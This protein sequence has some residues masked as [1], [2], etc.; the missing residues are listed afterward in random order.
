MYGR[1]RLLSSSPPGGLFSEPCS[2]SSKRYVV[3]EVVELSATGFRRLGLRRLGSAFRARAAAGRVAIAPA[4]ARA[5]HLHDVRDDLGG[6]LVL[7]VLVLPLARLQASFDVDLRALLEVLAR[8]LRELAEEGDAVPFRLLLHLAR[9]VLPLVGGR[10]GNVRDRA[11]VRHVARLRI[12]S[13]VAHQ[14]HLVH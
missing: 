1:G 13:E 11:A 5:E 2:T 7:A 14:N 9:L 10:D 8:D 12:A 3:F 6:V 4:L